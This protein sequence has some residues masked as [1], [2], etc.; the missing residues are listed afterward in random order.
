[1][2]DDALVKF[3]LFLDKFLFR[4]L[5]AVV[6]PNFNPLPRKETVPT[7]VV[8]MLFCVNDLDRVCRPHC[9]GLAVNGGGRA[10]SIRADVHH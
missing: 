4:P 9:R 2:I 1:V 6:S 5:N 7:N 10:E 3:G 8:E